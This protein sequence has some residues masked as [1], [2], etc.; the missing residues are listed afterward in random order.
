MDGSRISLIILAGGHSRRM[1]TDKSDLTYQ[2]KTFLEIQIRKALAL[3]ITDVMVS[4]YRGTPAG[5]PDTQVPVRFL[6]DRNPDK[7]PLGGLETCLRA[8]REWALVL[9]VDAPLVPPEELEK[10]ADHALTGEH[11]AVITE[12]GGNQYPLIGMYR[13]CLA[14]AMLEEFTQRKGS[15]FALLRRVGYTTWESQAQEQLFSN[16]NDPAAYARILEEAAKEP[17]GI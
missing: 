9:S 14:P 11:L 1:G 15:V 3:G 4:G 6:P 10:L 17:L 12:C 13:S 8:S 5:L 2:G 16:I 7:G